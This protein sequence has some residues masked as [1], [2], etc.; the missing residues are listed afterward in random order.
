MRKRTFTVAAALAAIGISSTHHAAAQATDKIGVLMM[1]G[2][3]PGSPNDPNFRSV[4]FRLQRE[5]MMVEMPDMPWSQRRY[6]D[7]NWDGVMQEM[8]GHVAAL[9]GK[10]A[11]KIVL[12]GHSMGCPAALSYAGRMK[13]VHALVLFAPGHAPRSYYNAPQLAAVRKSIDEAREMVAAG[14]G[15]EKGRFSD[16]NQ[17]RPLTVSMTAKDFLSYFDPES[18]ADMGVTAPKVPASI[19][20]LTVL[21]DA[22]PLF[23]FARAYFH[24]KLPPNPK[25]KYLEVSANHL[26]TP[27]AATDA[28]IAWMKDAVA[29]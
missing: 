18:D 12:M 22:D 1:H 13:D 26:T 29:G 28:A 7:G 19:P 27:G 15:A 4:L 17:G 24:D 5:G 3:N 23:K 25:T 20:V 21:G 8:T 6:L 14:K 2:K 11:T 9:R 16:I 10:G